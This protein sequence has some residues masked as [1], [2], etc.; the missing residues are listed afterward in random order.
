M[1]VKETQAI[2]VIRAS[3]LT[4]TFFWVLNIFKEANSV[5]KGF[6]NFYPPIGPLLGLF[7]FSILFLLILLVILRFVRPNNQKTAFWM[8]ILSSFLFFFMTFPPVFE[9]FVNLIRF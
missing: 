4:L 1:K 8:L 2:I 6:L 3:S 7:L 9:I 5:V